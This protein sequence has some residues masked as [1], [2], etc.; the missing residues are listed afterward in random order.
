MA[1][2]LTGPSGHREAGV[3]LPTLV[4]P[5]IPVYAFG[6]SLGLFLAITYVLCVVF[7]LLFPAHAMYPVWSRLLPGFTWLT[8]PSFFLG[9]RGD[10]RLRLVR[11]PDLRPALQFFR[12]ADGLG[13]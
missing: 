9:A 13:Q 3:Q 5:R 12:R 11:R 1:E 4:K 10:L 6:I 8:W 2:H 7:D